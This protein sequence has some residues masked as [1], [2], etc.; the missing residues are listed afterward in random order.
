MLELLD[1]DK[2]SSLL[3]QYKEKTMKKERKMVNYTQQSFKKYDNVK[4]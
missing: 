1:E 4:I 2:R 3:E